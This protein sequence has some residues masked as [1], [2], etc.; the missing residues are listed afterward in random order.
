MRWPKNECTILSEIFQAE[1]RF[2]HLRSINTSIVA[3]LANTPPA[4]SMAAATVYELKP[5]MITLDR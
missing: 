5:I 1:C 3:P 2:T 4:N